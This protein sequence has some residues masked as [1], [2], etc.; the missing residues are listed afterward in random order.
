MTH[1]LCN[2]TQALPWILGAACIAAVSL[3]AHAD[4][5]PPGVQVIH[6]HQPPYLDRPPGSG[7][8]SQ[9]DINDAMGL[10]KIGDAEAQAN[11]GI[12]LQTR[13]EYKE[14]AYW[15]QQAANA[16]VANAQYNMGTLYFNGE[17]VAQD[18]AKAHEWFMRAAKRGNKYAE[19]QLG[20]TYF[21]GQG[22]NKDPTKEIF[23]YEKAARHGVPAAAYNLGVIYNN[24]DEVA[25]DYVRAYA[26]LLLAQK[27]NLDTSSALS[28]VGTNLSPDQIKQAEKLSHTLERDPA[29]DAGR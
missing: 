12:M 22:V 5:L 16:G 1:S 20:M 29:S 4:R 26:W 17:G 27:G 18:Y 25:P 7:P 8:Y 3:P 13:G 9:S 19:F 28:A 14:A 23:W 21:T 10:A 11:L 6:M 2:I 15:Y 24:G